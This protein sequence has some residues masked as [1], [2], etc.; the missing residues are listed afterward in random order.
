MTQQQHKTPPHHS[1]PSQ[2]RK[3]VQQHQHDAS[4]RRESDLQPVYDFLGTIQPSHLRTAWHRID[5]RTRW[6]MVFMIAGIILLWS[7]M[8]ISF[9]VASHIEAT[10]GPFLWDALR[11]PYDL[12]VRLIPTVDLNADP[13]TI[14]L[15]PTAVGD[16]ALQAEPVEEVTGEETVEQAVPEA[17]VDETT[18]AADNA[19]AP[20]V[21]Y[22]VSDCL[23]A[24]GAP[25]DK[26]A[27]VSAVAQY[28]ESGDYQAAQ[29]MPIH[30]TMA[31]FA[32]D[33][34]AT[35]VARD[36]H[37]FAFSIGSVGN[38]ALGVGQADFFYGSTSDL[39]TFAWSHGTWVLTASSSR[40]D[41][42][43]AFV[44]AFPY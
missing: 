3:S 19:A 8:R 36:L 26:A 25:I 4:P 15:L 1:Q 37:R 34:E 9:M 21:I 16:Y 42:L 22:P 20:A 41:D 14:T 7:V 12:E 32:S 17:A 39:Y 29:G 18:A 6:L 24:G 38:F 35:Q 40:F 2:R 5:R 10:S 13:A 28:I 44:Q 30:L 23:Y 31:Q 43:E 33:Y 11:A 27:C